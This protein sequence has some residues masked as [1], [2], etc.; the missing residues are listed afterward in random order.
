MKKKEITLKFLKK[1]GG[2]EM[3]KSLVIGMVVTIII[4]VLFAVTLAKSEAQ[5]TLAGRWKV[6]ESQ[7][8]YLL[9]ASVSGNYTANYIHANEVVPCS[10]VRVSGNTI[11]MMC[12]WFVG[13]QGAKSSFTFDLT[14]S[15]DRAMFTGTMMLSTDYWDTKGNPGHYDAPHSVIFVR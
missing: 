14:L 6:P 7:S 11:H 8:R 13:D 15:D 4:F 12:K 3:K 1:A 9:I 5:S 10:D 2:Q